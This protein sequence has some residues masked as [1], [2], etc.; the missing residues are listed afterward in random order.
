MTKER[1]EQHLTQIQEGVRHLTVM[2]DEIL[3][4]SKAQSG[5]LEFK[6][7]LLD[8]RDFCQT[9]T[10]KI[11]VNAERNRILLDFSGTFCHLVYVDPTLLGQ[12]LTNLLMNAIKYSPEGGDVH[13]S[14]TCN[15]REICFKVADQG[16]GIPEADQKHLFEVFRRGTN[17]GRFPGTGL[18]LAIVRE[19]LRAHHGSVT[20]ES[21]LG[22][23]SVFTLTIPLVL[24]LPE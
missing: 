19:T 5:G 4:L 11:Q 13:F 12:A 18:G 15:T 1:A 7:V 21:Q 10:E 6:P 9:V 16:I 3:T 2:L 17:V 23:G 24:T 22:Q 14:V 8:L 20:L